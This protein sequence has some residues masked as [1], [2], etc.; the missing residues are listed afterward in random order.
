MKTKLFFFT[1][2][3]INLAAHAQESYRFYGNFSYNAIVYEVR[4]LSNESSKSYKI[5][6]CGNDTDCEESVSLSND[7]NQDIFFNALT[8]VMNKPKL[9]LSPV[10]DINTNDIR[11]QWKN[12][13]DKL[14]KE[15]NK[16]EVLT[17]LY[18]NQGVEYSGK[19]SL[20]KDVTL[21]FIKKVK[22]STGDTQNLDEDTKKKTVPNAKKDNEPAKSINFKP[23]YASIR[24]FNNRI[25]TVAV[26][27]TLSNE[28]T[29]RTLT[30]NVF[31]IPF[32]FVIK[33]G[34]KLEVEYN[35]SIYEM[36]WNDLLDYKPE[37]TEYNYSVKN[38]NY[39]LKPGEEVKVESRNLF[40]YF[41]AI[42]FTDFLGLNDNGN[43]S[44][45]LAEGRAVI[46][47]ALVN[48]NRINSP[49]YFE[50]YLTTSIYNG[51]EEGSGFVVWKAPSANAGVTE[52]INT[53]D[54]FK[55][56]NI[57][58]GLNLGL[59]SLEWR[60]LSSTF[61]LDYGFQFYRSKLRYI[62][63][64]LNNYSDLQVYSIGHG[65]KIKIEIRPQVNFGAD[66][67]IGL[68]GFNYNG[69]NKQIEYSG[70]FK[71]DVLIKNNSIYNG[72][73][74]VSNFYTKLNDKENN[75]GLYF[76]LGV[77]YD[78]YSS[79]VAPQIMVGYATN[80]TS[81]I[82]KFKKKDETVTP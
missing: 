4:L 70:N 51:Q 66:L 50:A 68:M 15:I 56:R 3:L 23:E 30:N 22:A 73:F 16:K 53:F 82:N 18:D 77:N 67:N 58:A 21:R 59:V 20:H 81:F 34:S 57:E 41:T 48:K 28:E 80:L 1:F 33:N 43:N 54:F 13:Y 6:I 36:Q 38:K 25:N 65:P 17:E 39:K 45:L 47:M 60:G 72:L 61:T 69:L 46:P 10:F 26:V 32:R 71:Q 2:F 64:S 62:K 19:I 7:Y 49:Q 78:F 11:T 40:D 5:K 9:V 55:K 14:M 79:D 27:G 52:K 29:P 75:N 44:L 63:D 31:S 12:I 8:A 35:S 24:F 42:I 76:R 37:G 74:V